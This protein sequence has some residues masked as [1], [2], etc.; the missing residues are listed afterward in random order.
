MESVIV[1]NLRK[2]NKIKHS[3]TSKSY[4]KY[5]KNHARM[6]TYSKYEHATT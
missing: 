1:H 6:Q 5:W 3:V 2:A 4:H